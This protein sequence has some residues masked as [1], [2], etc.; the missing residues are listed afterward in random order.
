M[1]VNSELKVLSHKWQSIIT[2]VIKLCRHL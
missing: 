1:A 2:N